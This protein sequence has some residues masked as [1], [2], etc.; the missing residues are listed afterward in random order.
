MFHW[1]A[2]PNFGG[3]FSYL[4]HRKMRRLLLLFITLTFFF[5]LPLK[6][7]DSNTV[8]LVK[9]ELRILTWNI[10]MLPALITF[11][12]KVKRAKGI[13]ALLSSSDYDVIVLQETFHHRARWKL[14]KYLREAYPHFTKPL[15]K[16]KLSFKLSG[17][18]MIF[19]KHPINKV[20]EMKFSES[21][22]MDKI[23]RKGALYVQILKDDQPI[24]IIGTHITSSGPM[25]IR[26]NQAKEMKTAFFQEDW[27]NTPTI[28]LGDFN[29]PKR[30]ARFQE[31][32]QILNSDY[33]NPSADETGTWGSSDNDFFKETIFNRELD[34][35]FWMNNNVQLIQQ[36]QQIKKY[37]SDYSKRRKDLSD[38]YGIDAYFEWKL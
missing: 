19:S 3:R 31:L 2:A 6:S 33:F 38:H 16:K 4:Y 9:N 28:F 35:T 25:E 7:Q 34:Y 12:K 13:T 23:S 10:Y 36:Q 15:N 8:E 22:G 37:K 5:G 32:P 18:V 29:I 1:K 27:M 21:S 26:L 14:K 24:N 11:T 30:H 20:L 17:G